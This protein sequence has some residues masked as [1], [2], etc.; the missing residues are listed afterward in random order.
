MSTAAWALLLGL[1]EAVEPASNL[2]SLR[3]PRSAPFGVLQLAS[4][5][6]LVSHGRL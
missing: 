2:F 5:F 6:L 1:G 3:L 4:L